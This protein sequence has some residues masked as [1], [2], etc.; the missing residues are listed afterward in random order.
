MDKVLQEQLE[1][2]R[3]LTGFGMTANP[4]DGAELRWLQKP[5]YETRK[6][7]LAETFDELVLEGPGT[8]SI[9]HEKTVS[10]EG[11]VK[12]TVPT[13]LAIRE[14]HGRAYALSQLYRPLNREDLS[15]FNRISVWLYIEAAGFHAVYTEISVHNAGEH[16]M[17]KPGRFEGTHFICLEPFKWH[18]VVWEI[19]YIYRDQVTA[20]SM[21]VSLMGNLPEASESISVYYDDLRLEV[22]EEENYSGFN[23]RKNGIAYCH[24]G[25]KCGTRKQALVQYQGEK[26]FSLYDRAGS[27]V[28]KGN[29]I[30]VQ[31][32]FSILDFSSFDI[33]GLYTLKIGNVTS[34]PFYIG[35]EAYHAAA[36]KT[37]N[38]FYT[39][40]CGFDVPGVHSACHLDVTNYHPD[41]RRI[42]TAGGWHDA[43]D[44]S[45][46]LFK[47]IECAYAIADLA[48][49]T[50]GKDDALAAR[51]KDELRWG[52]NWIMRTRFGDGY[53]A[54]GCTIGIW[55]D[56]VI[57]TKD[58]LDRPAICNSIENFFAAAICARSARMFSEDPFFY[59]WCLRCAKED[60]EFAEARAG[61]PDEGGYTRLVFGSVAGL[62]GIELYQTT[63]EQRYLDSA[64]HW[65][66][67][68]LACQQQEP[69]IDFSI[70]L[71]GFFYETPE[72]KR[73]QSY[74]H[75]SHEHLPL[76]LLYTLYQTT[77]EHK[78]APAWKKGLSL[79]GSYIRDTADLIAPYSLLPSAIYELDNT[80][81]SRF[82]H[83]G[84]RSKGAPSL[85]EYNAQVK[86]GILLN[87]GYYLRRFPVAYQFRGFHAT[88][89]SKAKAAFFVYKAL[90]GDD[91]KNIAIRQIEWVL[92]FNPYASSSC[93]GEGYDYAPLYVAFSD[94]LVGAVPVGFETFEN[95]DVPFYPM[96]IAPT[97]KEVW[98]QTTCRLMWLIADLM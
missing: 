8:L 13:T 26:E 42:G 17:P 14:P 96:Q 67:L 6:L 38:F 85:E 45:Q 68:V 53:R 23:L 22:V 40:R 66:L 50:A 91:L 80:D 90:G 15:F 37:L 73:I 11:S 72:K 78:D 98:G 84:D 69:R 56:N 88:L 3:Y 93:Y 29:A 18:H 75:R 5:V 60:F 61:L 81:Y 74:Y 55:T 41:G 46:N 4:E 1:A 27:V 51:A 64:A 19:P 24:S 65:A 44:L 39:E 32:D 48:D 34:K 62:A 97:Y 2:S 28:F 70:P 7:P 12:I 31:D 59:N 33:S 57:G 94:Q 63:G 89:M 20:I 95:E 77:P 16:I 49:A 25:Y 9:C 54:S 79:Y 10:A 47:N 52:L 82:S 87:E 35:E 36:W 92:G 58:D 30:P 76:Q 71:T 83:E 21:G 86:N 43:G